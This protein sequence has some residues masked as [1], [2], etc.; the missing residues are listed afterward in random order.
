MDKG[1]LAI[2]MCA[3]TASGAFVGSF[4]EALH[5]AHYREALADPNFYHLVDQGGNP[6]SQEMQEPG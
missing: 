4:S 5:D 3:C 6:V 1:I 2:M